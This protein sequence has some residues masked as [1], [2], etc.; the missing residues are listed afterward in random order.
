LD[1]EVAG[2]LI[3]LIFSGQAIEGEFLLGLLDHWRWDR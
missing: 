2:R 1:T 3:G